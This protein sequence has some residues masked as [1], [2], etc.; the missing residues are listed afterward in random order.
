[1]KM[2]LKALLGII[3]SFMCL[4]TCVGYAQL[5]DELQI[6]GTASADM[7]EGLFITSVI[8]LGS[9]GANGTVNSFTTTVVNS[10]T[11]LG[12]NKNGSVTYTITVF[13]NTD[14]VYGY[15]GMIYTTGETTY[16]NTNIKTIAN[17]ERRMA[18][19]P[20]QYI[21]FDVT[22]S[23]KN[24]SSISNTV[25][26][27]IVT[28]EFLPL[29]KIPEN[30][31]E[32]AVNG[33]LDQFKDILNNDVV[34]YPMSYQTL[35]NQMNDYD[36]N[37]RHDASYIGNVKGA[38]QNDTNLLNELFAGTLSLNIN[39]VETPVTVMI[40]S[41][42]A[43]GNTANGNEMVIYMTTDD[44]QSSGG[45]FSSSTAP[46]YTAVFISNA[47]SEWNQIG[48]LYLGNATIKQYNGWP[49]SG[50]F[51]T[52]TWAAEAQTYKVTDHY[53]Y[54]IAKNTS[55][56]NIMKATDANANNELIRLLTIANDIVNDGR[57]N[58][59][60][61]NEVEAEMAKYSEYFTIE[62]G[63]VTI[64]NGAT[65][66]HLIPVILALDDVLSDIEII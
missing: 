64:I 19:S 40:K 54:T 61:V 42:N 5:N 34:N 55:I 52:D 60:I 12:S 14:I 31:D 39:G 15:N 21:S 36:A 41:E 26:N 33:V 29:D 28:Y 10:I 47:S 59:D 38:S 13:N 9:N 63:S 6:E 25:L 17:I 8:P 4:F 7:P 23:Y 22:V 30:E 1:M 56:E 50:S 44:L 51:D 66:A 16:D 43:D 57:Y 27:S 53:S 3:L 32:I 49:G 35:V 18:V 65:R 58:S 2:W 46:V 37:D 45:W 11:N 20:G 48:D 24:T 62:N